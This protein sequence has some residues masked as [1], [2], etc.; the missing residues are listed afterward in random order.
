[1]RC[2]IVSKLRRSG[3]AFAFCVVPRRFPTG[4]EIREAACSFPNLKLCGLCRHRDLSQAMA[5]LRGHMKM[6]PF[7][8]LL[9]PESGRSRGQ[10]WRDW[11]WWWAGALVSLVL[12][13][14][15]DLS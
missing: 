5:F 3:V 10:W 4:T 9:L 15:V 12:A 13:C 8:M 6:P 11:V 14:L 1:M 2:Q 7:K